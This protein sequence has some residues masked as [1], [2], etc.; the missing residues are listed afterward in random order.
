MKDNVFE[1]TKQIIDDFYQ[2]QIDFINHT[3]TS[4]CVCGCV[5]TQKFWDLI[6]LPDIFFKIILEYCILPHN[7]LLLT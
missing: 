3:E 1:E 6:N 4:Y 2:T 7:I 5:D